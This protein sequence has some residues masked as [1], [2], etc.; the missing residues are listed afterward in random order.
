MSCG[1]DQLGFPINTKNENISRNQPMIIH[2]VSVQ[3]SFCEK[4]FI[5][6]SLKPLVKT[7]SCNEDKKR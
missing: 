6:F 3:S 5:C 2:V 7:Y 1:C 4:S